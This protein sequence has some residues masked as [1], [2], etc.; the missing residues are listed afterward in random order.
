MVVVCDFSQVY[1]Q[2]RPVLHS[3]SVPF[4]TGSFLVLGAVFSVIARV[5]CPP[6]EPGTIFAPSD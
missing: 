3:K 4:H 1:L 5:F 2:V 6:F